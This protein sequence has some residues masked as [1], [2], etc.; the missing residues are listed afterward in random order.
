MISKKIMAHHKLKINDSYDWNSDN[1]GRQ[2][3]GS[4]KNDR[5]F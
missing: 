2:A 1:V 5:F 4:S 3:G